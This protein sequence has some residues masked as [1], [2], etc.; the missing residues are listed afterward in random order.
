MKNVGCCHYD[1][2]G[3][4]ELFPIN[5]HFYLNS[6]ANILSF[7][8]I[9]FIPG[10]KITTDTSIERSL[11]VHFGND[12]TFKFQACDDGLYYY[13][14]TE[15]CNNSNKTKNSV[16]NYRNCTSPSVNSNSKGKPLTLL[17]TVEYN[18]KLYSKR[19]IARADFAR[20]LQQELGWPGN[21]AFRNLI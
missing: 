4:C 15:I 20:K 9:A 12:T 16:S 21:K 5:V 7:D 17:N 6:I 8:K 18:K 1:Q 2:V 19:Q 10:V 11:M 3:K 14:A 13:D